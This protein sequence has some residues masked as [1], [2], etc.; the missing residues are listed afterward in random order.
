M[1]SQNSSL[2]VGSS[3]KDTASTS[4]SS[5]AGSSKSTSSSSNS[6]STPRTVFVVTF[7][8]YDGSVLQKANVKKGELPVYLGET[9]KRIGDQA[10]NYTFKTWSKEIVP[11]VSDETYT[12]VF[13]QVSIASFAFS[14]ISAKDSYRCISYSGSE[15]DIEIPSSYS[16]KKVLVVGDG[17]NSILGSNATVKK[18]RLP[19]EVQY[20][21]PAAFLDSKLLEEFQAGNLLTIFG[22]A[23]QGCTGLKTVAINDECSDIKGSAFNG[24]SAL[25]TV[26]LPSSLTSV[27]EWLFYGCTSLQTI[28]IPSSV[29]S[30]GTCAFSGC[31]ALQEITI[32][33]N[34]KAINER[35]FNDLL[36]LQ[37]I[38]YGATECADFDSSGLLESA[39]KDAG[40]I[41]L[42][43][44]KNVKRVPAYFCYPGT[45]ETS[46]TKITKVV[47][48]NGSI[49]SEVGVY[50]IYSPYLAT[51]VIPA[52]CTNHSTNSFGTWTKII[53]GDSSEKHTVVFKNYDGSVL[54]SAEYS[55]GDM[56]VFSGENPQKPQDE[57]T[58]YFSGWDAPI[59]TVT[60]DATY[61]ATFTGVNFLINGVNGAN[62]KKGCPATITN[63]ALVGGQDVGSAYSSVILSKITV[64]IKSDK[65]SFVLEGYKDW[66]LTG[67]HKINFKILGE[68]GSVIES[69]TLT[70]ASLALN[71][72]F[73]VSTDGFSLAA[74]E[75]KGKTVTLR[76]NYVA[77]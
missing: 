58:F 48:E 32:G 10:Y 41:T 16:G 11:A 38:N 54:Q 15:E 57:S 55:L 29:V 59:A 71:E 18:V 30:I 37:R 19:D 14:Y 56:P 62:P 63:N 43:I 34:V 73:S 20:V 26:H 75:I 77:W 25:K 45:S 47:F 60:E 22:S 1:I 28:A 70:T 40:G 65:I 69:G 24:C 21:N 5:Q 36:R 66:G 35:A 4:S 27:S 68:T 39:G 53:T 67:P 42:T 31:N 64:A 6:S 17:T 2:G 7:E 51:V 74:D 49:C 72:K 12:A 61:T 76:L 52:T 23:F 3:S 9:P 46:S 33:E 13:S 44:A 50:G 8:N